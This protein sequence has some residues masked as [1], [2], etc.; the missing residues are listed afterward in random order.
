MHSRTLFNKKVF[1]RLCA[2]AIFFYLS[3]SNTYA[4]NGVPT[5]LSFQGRLAN[6]SGNLVGSSSGTLYY[7]KF[8]IWDVATSGTAIPDR[9]WPAG[10]PGTTTALVRQGV[11]NVNIGDMASGYPDLLNYNFNTNK[12]IYL[13]IEVSST[14][15]G[16]FETLSPR[17]RISSAPFAQVS[18]AVSGVGQSSFGTTT[19]INNSIVSIFST[20]TDSTALTV[21]G[22]LNQAADL[23]NIQNS[24]GTS[25]FSVNSLGGI[26]GSSTLVI[27]SST[28]TSFIVDNNGH[29][30]VGTGA[31]GRRFDVFDVNTV[32]PQLRLSQSTS[33]YAEF[34]VDAAGDL[35]ISSP[36]GGIGGNIRLDDQNLF[37]CEGA[38]CAV[39]TPTTTGNII[40]ENSVIFDNK[41]NLRQIDAST[42]VMYDS[43][44][45]PI[46]EFDE[47]Q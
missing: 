45:N 6:S 43:I 44:D 12:D 42:T 15:N 29:V 33:T 34:Q 22:F 9:L 30:G 35:H 36:G 5:I 24:S 14:S 31:P 10:A 23:F 21:R 11:F 1:I 38:A 8:S 2:I 17:Q 26:L 25:M 37:V 39:N 27:G 16:T 13:Q 41:F 47:G 46:L 28:A 3:V 32:N 4:A 18:G 20:S 40:V 19:P 7:F